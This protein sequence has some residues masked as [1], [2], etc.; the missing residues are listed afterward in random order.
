MKQT[1]FAKIKNGNISND[2]NNIDPGRWRKA[3][4]NGFIDGKKYSLH[5]FKNMTNNHV[6]NIKYIKDWVIYYWIDVVILFKDKYRQ[7]CLY[8]NMSKKIIIH[9]FIQLCSV[10]L[11]ALYHM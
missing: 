8:G 1:K 9:S 11:T 10:S 7:H 6:F 2:L 4:Q 3:Y 5:Y